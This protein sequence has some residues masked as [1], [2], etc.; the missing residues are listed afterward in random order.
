[1]DLIVD[2]AAAR[3]SRLNHG[4]VRKGRLQSECAVFIGRVGRAALNGG[5]F[6]AIFEGLGEGSDMIIGCDQGLNIIFGRVD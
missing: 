5:G 1:M 6:A 2:A 4:K 3:L